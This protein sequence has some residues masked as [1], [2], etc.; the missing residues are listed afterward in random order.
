MVKLIHNFSIKYTIKND[1]YPKTL[2]GAVDLMRK[3]KFKP[4]KNNDKSNTQKQNK[5]GGDEQYKSNE[6]SFEQTQKHQ[7]KCYCCG[8][9]THMLNNCEIRYTIAIYQWFER[10]GSVYSHQQQS[11]DKGYEKRCKVMQI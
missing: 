2:Q 11:S 3:V 5:N 8:S 4:E 1:E 10:T 9:G 7:K 6:T